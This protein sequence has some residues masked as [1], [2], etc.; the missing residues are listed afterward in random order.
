MPQAK[1]LAP[2]EAPAPV[3]AEE[4]RFI[5]EVIRR[6]YGPTAIVRNWGPDPKRLE[7]HVEA[8]D[9]I[10]MGHHDCA[11]ELLAEIARDSIGLEV[12]HRGMKVRGSAKLAY[13]QG[14]ILGG[15]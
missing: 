15:G 14:V 6:Y 1:P 9:D 8:D 3:S 5:L 10:G 7:L 11:G 12:T 2:P 4:E 13:R